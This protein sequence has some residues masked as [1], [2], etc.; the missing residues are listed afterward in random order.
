MPVVE[1]E[2]YVEG[3]EVSKVYRAGTAEAIEAVCSV[4]FTVPRGQFV[5]VLGPSGCGKSTLLIGTSCFP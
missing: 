2:R 5:A 3:A 4:G 1:H